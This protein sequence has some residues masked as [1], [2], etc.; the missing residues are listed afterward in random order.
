MALGNSHDC[1]SIILYLSQL[2]C[3][4]KAGIRWL[5]SSIIPCESTYDR[6]YVRKIL[7]AN[8]VI[9]Y[10]S[11]LAV[12]LDMTAIPVLSHVSQLPTGCMSGICWLQTQH[13]SIWV[14]YRRDVYPEY[15]DRKSS[16]ILYESTTAKELCWLQI[17]YFVNESWLWGIPMTAIP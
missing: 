17:D 15:V 8:P 14:N 12:N 5:K 3:N 10:M 16:T 1:N 9:L 11:Q 2:L 4:S 13:Y 7:T 6:I